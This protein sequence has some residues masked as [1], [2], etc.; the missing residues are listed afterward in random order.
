MGKTTVDQ[1]ATICWTDLLPSYSP[2]C[3]TKVTFQGEVCDQATLDHVVAPWLG[4]SRA[5]DGC[6]E[7]GMKARLQ[8]LSESTT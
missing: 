8:N 1:E 3:S 5:P 7:G 4:Q 2:H 6:S